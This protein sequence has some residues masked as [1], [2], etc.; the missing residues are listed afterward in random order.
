MCRHPVSIT[1]FGLSPTFLFYQVPYSYCPTT[2]ARNAFRR[3]SGSNP[4]RWDY[5]SAGI[6][7]P[8]TEEDEERQREKKRRQREKKREK[9]RDKKAA[10]KEL[11]E[12]VCQYSIVNT[13]FNLP[14]LIGEKQ[15][16]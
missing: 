2:E 5:K 7:A 4:E 1:I 9:D 6:P 11:R 10:E 3:F 16:T 14:C 15:K 8:L 12:Q 13:V